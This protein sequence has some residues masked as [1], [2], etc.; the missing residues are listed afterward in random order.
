MA[1]IKFL[2][3]V[4][5]ANDGVLRNFVVP[6][7][8][9]IIGRLVIPCL[10]EGRI[11][12][13]IIEIKRPCPAELQ[14]ITTHEEKIMGGVLKNDELCGLLIAMKLHATHEHMFDKRQLPPL[15]GSSRHFSNKDLNAKLLRNESLL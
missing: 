8:P 6:G 14:V 2:D 11:H 1:E 3:F 5:K 12:D 15:P 13:G 10:V 4:E 7:E 9:A